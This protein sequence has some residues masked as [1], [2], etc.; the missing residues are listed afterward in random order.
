MA[1]TIM[2]LNKDPVA[3]KIVAASSRYANAELIYWGPLNLIT[4]KTYVKPKITKSPGDKFT[5]ISA[6]M[7][8]RPDQLSQS[9]YGTPEYW[10][11]IMEY[12]GMKD[13]MEFKA[14]TNI[15]LPQNIMF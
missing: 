5:V 12:N 4:F 8:Y 2:A 14:G 3:N 10:W 9:A 7:E 11:K 6:G 15:I 1:N 13:I